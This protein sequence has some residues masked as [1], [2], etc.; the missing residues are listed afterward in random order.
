MGTLGNASFRCPAETRKRHERVATQDKLE[1]VSRSSGREAP[2]SLKGLSV[3]AKEQK[4]G[5]REAKK[6]KKEKAASKSADPFANQTKLATNTNIRR[7]KGKARW[8]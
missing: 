3:M 5:N 4:R 8:S 2:L 1:L 6:P 7:A